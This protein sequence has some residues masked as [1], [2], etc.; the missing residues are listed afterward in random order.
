MTDAEFIM[1]SEAKQH[2]ANGKA[3]YSRASRGQAAKAAA[4]P[5]IT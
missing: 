4:C 5:L 3:V 2:K 1:R